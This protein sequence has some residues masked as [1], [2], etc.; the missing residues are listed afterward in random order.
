MAQTEEERKARQRAY[1]QAHKEDYKRRGA[2]WR[3]ANSEKQRE[4][5]RQSHERNKEARNARSR[6]WKA[7]NPE[8]ARAANRRAHGIVDPPGE[9]RH[10][11]CPVCLR[12]MPLVCDHWHEGPRKGQIRGWLCR[13]CNLMLGYAFDAPENLDRGKAYLLADRP[14]VR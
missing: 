11:E 10:G 7:A 8:K 13:G 4:Y 2:E 12:A 3:A 9:A 14:E 6:A 1:Y 5:S